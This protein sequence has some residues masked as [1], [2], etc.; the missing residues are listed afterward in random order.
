MPHTHTVSCD[1]TVLMGVTG[2]PSQDLRLSP[3]VYRSDTVP[4]TSADE[5]LW[6][7]YLFPRVSSYRPPRW[8]TGR[9]RLNGLARPRAASGWDAMSVCQQRKRKRNQ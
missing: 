8:D 2:A 9:A 5:R 6:A 7:P 3:T 1:D 4:D